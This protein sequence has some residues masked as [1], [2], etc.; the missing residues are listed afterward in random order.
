MKR[1]ANGEQARTQLVF[2]IEDHP[3]LTGYEISKKLKWSVGKV[4][5]HLKQLINSGEVRVKKEGRKKLLFAVSW[6]EMVV[7]GNLRTGKTDLMN[8][9]IEKMKK[10]GKSVT[11]LQTREEED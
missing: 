1:L 10:Q 11:I 9:E 5:Y 8:K 2:Y 7:V 6:L 4:F 3:G